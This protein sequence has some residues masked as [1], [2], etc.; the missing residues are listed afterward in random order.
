MP[1]LFEVVA[2][3]VTT[4]EQQEPIRNMRT[5][6]ELE[7]NIDEVSKLHYNKQTKKTDCKILW[8]N[9]LYNL[10]MIY[11]EI[12]CRVLNPSRRGVK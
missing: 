10:F 2:D 4:D 3:G 1:A 8:Y 7:T 11:Y 9:V 5:I 6:L 12:F